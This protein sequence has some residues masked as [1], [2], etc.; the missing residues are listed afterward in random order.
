MHIFSNFCDL[1]DPELLLS[2]LWK[3]QIV[4]KFLNSDCSV[5]FLSFVLFCF[6]FL[7]E[8]FL[9]LVTM[10][11]MTFWL[12]AVK[13]N[14]TKF[15]VNLPRWCTDPRNYLSFFSVLGGSKIEIALVLVYYGFETFFHNLYLGHAILFMDKLYCNRFIRGFSSSKLINFWLNLYALYDPLPTIRIFSRKQYMFVWLNSSI[16]VV[17]IAII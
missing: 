1:N 12:I 4:F 11:F 10:N 15:G 14:C 8:H 7:K 17:S 6:S 2:S 16:T 3:H 9:V 5:C 13:N